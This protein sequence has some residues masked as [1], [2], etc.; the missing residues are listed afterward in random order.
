MTDISIKNIETIKSQINSKQSDYTH[1]G[2][3]NEAE[4]TLTDFDHF[5]YTRFYRGVYYSSEPLVSSREAGWKP[6][7]NNCY[8]P[9]CSYEKQDYPDNCFQYACS[10]IFPCNVGKKSDK[11]SHEK[12]NTTCI[13]QYR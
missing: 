8:T 2:T 12:F 6:H 10:T 5:P 11:N 4:K 7:Q 3:I 9:N 13:V 1:F